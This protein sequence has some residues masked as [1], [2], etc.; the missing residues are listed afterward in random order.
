M[1]AFAELEKIGAENPSPDERPP[2]RQEKAPEKPAP[3]AAEAKK[4]EK[5]AAEAPKQAQDKPKDST[6]GKQPDAGEKPTEGE[7]PLTGEDPSKKFQLAS[8]LR[9]DYRRLHAENERLAN[10]LKQARNGKGEP[11]EQA[12]VLGSKVESLEKRNRELEEEIS[13]R[14]YTK[15]TDFQD[16]FKKP[17]E[18]KLARVYRQVADLYVRDAEGNERPATREDFDRV[19]ES[20]QADARRVAKEIFGEEDFREVLQYRR[21]LNELQQ[22]ADEEMKNWREKAKER[23]ATRISEERKVREQAEVS[24]R[25][26]TETYSEK[27]PQW[28]GN[29]EGDEE[30]NKALEDGFASVD[31]SQ[32]RNLPLDQRV[33]LLA[34]TRLKAASFGRHVITIK[35]LQSR[36]AELEETLKGY[37]K[38]EPGEGQGQRSSSVSA[39]NGEDVDDVS[40][41]IDEIERRNPV[42]R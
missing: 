17:F 11:D 19:L 30:L 9:R 29:V 32:D 12:K 22:N 18:N 38:S 34:A 25:K 40:K 36:V 42:S 16:K 28:F 2:R 37:E 33:D 41:E 5:P 24:F 10:E 26:S 7:K 8:D 1:D 39:A 27:Y 21:E 20:G 4:P 31:K 6:E 14:D 23:E 15:S 13:Y 3:K 35:R